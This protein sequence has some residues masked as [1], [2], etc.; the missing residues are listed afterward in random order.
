[1][2]SPVP[3]QTGFARQ[4]QAAGAVRP[5]LARDSRPPGSGLTPADCRFADLAATGLRDRLPW[6]LLCRK[7]TER[8]RAGTYPHCTAIARHIGVADDYRCTDYGLLQHLLRLPADRS[9]DPVLH[10]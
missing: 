8:S 1:T 7:G 9:A 6:P 10:L 5:D 3:H 2:K 4:R